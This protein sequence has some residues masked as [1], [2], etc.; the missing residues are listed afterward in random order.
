M[1]AAVV[2][3][4]SLPIIVVIAL[5]NAAAFVSARIH[6]REPG[7]ASTRRCRRWRGRVQKEGAI[8]LSGC[9]DRRGKIW[10]IAAV[11][12]ATGALAL[13]G[14]TSTVNTSEPTTQTATP[15]AQEQQDEF[16][17]EPAAEKTVT[18]LPAGPL[19]WHVENFPALAEAEA[20]AGPLSLAAD[21]EGKV[22]LFTLSPKGAPMHGGS[23]VTE[24]GPLVDVSAPEYLLRISH[25]VAAPGAKSEVHTHPGTEAFFVLKGQL[26]QKTPHGV[27]VVDAGE[28]L[29]GG[30]PEHPMEVTSSGGEELH[31][32]IM[33]VVDANK[34]FL[35]P[36]TFE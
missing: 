22:W 8:V 34:P 9:H 4:V 16:V 3:A 10:R 5:L 31:E 27:N 18:E 30:A 35:S 21:V 15:T 1:S 19:Y 13:S 25:G 6:R 29:A 14:C 20:A 17:V 28:T 26:S 36:A 7:P 33:F 24:I 23:M 11:F 2:V 32:L 12:A